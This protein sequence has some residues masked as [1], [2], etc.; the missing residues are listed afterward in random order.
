MRDFQ[1]RRGDVDVVY[2]A[3]AV[4]DGGGIFA[5]TTTTAAND[6]TTERMCASF[7]GGEEYLTIPTNC[8]RE[9]TMTFNTL[10]KR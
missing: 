5:K 10:T 8:V 3:W 7:Y 9:R 1:C 2:G 6:E 4:P